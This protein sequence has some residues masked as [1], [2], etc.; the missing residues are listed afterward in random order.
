MV[1]EFLDFRQT[2][3]TVTKITA[4]FKERALL[5]LHYVAD[6]DIEG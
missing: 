2:T 6:E 4:K 3:E 1:S 5:V